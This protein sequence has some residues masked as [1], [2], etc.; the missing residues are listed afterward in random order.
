MLKKVHKISANPFRKL[1][2]SLVAFIFLCSLIVAPTFGGRSAG[3]QIYPDPGTSV[4]LTASFQPPVLLGLKIHPENPLLFDFIV[5]QGSLS[6]SQEELGFETEKLV[7]YFLAALTIPDKEVWVNLS[8]YEK[9]RII[10]DVLGQTIMGKTMLEQ[11]YLLKQLASSLTNPDTDLG[12]EYWDEVHKSTSV[13]ARAKQ[14]N[15]SGI[16]SLPAEVRNDGISEV[17]NDGISEAR[18]DT[19]A[20]VWI[21]PQKAEVLESHGIVIVGEKRLKVMMDED[22]SESLATARAQEYDEN[23]SSP[24]VLIGDPQ[25]KNGFPLKASGNDS[26]NISSSI[27]RSTILPAIEK[28]VNEGKNFADL[29]QIYNSVILAAW[30]KQALKESL[31]GKIYADQGK[32][33]GV[34][35][36]DKDMKKRIYEQYVAA[37]KKG[38]YNIIKEESDSATGDMIPRK[39]FSGGITIATFVASSALSVRN[40]SSAEIEKNL[41]EKSAIS[42]V[43]VRLAENREAEAVASSPTGNADDADEVSPPQIGSFVR[44]FIPK[45]AQF[46]EPLEGKIPGANEPSERQV[47]EV[48]DDTVNPLQR[49]IYQHLTE[50]AL[51]ISDSAIRARIS[52]DLLASAIVEKIWDIYVLGQPNNDLPNSQTAVYYNATKDLSSL[53]AAELEATIVVLKALGFTRNKTKEIEDGHVGYGADP[54]IYGYRLEDGQWANY[55]Q[56]SARLLTEHT[57]VMP[58]IKSA[59]SA[60]T[61]QI[62]KA[63][64]R[65]I[66][67]SFGFEKDDIADRFVAFIILEM[68]EMAAYGGMTLEG[69]VGLNSTHWANILD[70]FGVGPRQVENLNLMMKKVGMTFPDQKPRPFPEKQTLYVEFSERLQRQLKTAV[71]TLPDMVKAV[72]GYSKTILGLSAVGIPNEELTIVMLDNRTAVVALKTMLIKNT[73]G[74]E[75]TAD[76]RDI[77]KF[78]GLLNQD[79]RS[80]PFSVKIALNAF[81]LPETEKQIAVPTLIVQGM[82]SSSGV[83]QAESVAKNVNKKNLG[84]INFDPTNMNLQIKRDGQGVP[85]PLP[86]QNLEQ[87]NIQ[88]FFP[89]IINIQPVNTQTLPLLLGQGEPQE[90]L[91]F[92]N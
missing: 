74:S 87:I 35:T 69:I 50:I 79:G 2:A 54:Q 47:P 82:K 34:E 77:L 88:G 59:S 49:D 75:M 38:V 6:L 30:Y 81:N 19:F 68:R 48:L 12:N 11:D 83:K 23:L 67:D 58:G 39:Y 76:Q 65:Q 43:T 28:E 56:L 13:I 31:L 4:G 57:I 16:A 21:V 90:K 20:K 17:R 60:L 62:A 64:A 61:Y 51:K 7:K 9:D 85:L 44:S 52:Y 63:Q 15:S 45:A 55:N 25:S 41:R 36:D 86:Q 3:A 66:L 5:D 8:P 33:A 80:I 72:E 70:V 26:K 32:V 89:V 84:G 18:N 46:V 14:S 40:V 22:R 27:F 29:R 10:P 1:T 42:T 91:S 92:L 37:F 78:H 71:E 73:D 24:N 53:S